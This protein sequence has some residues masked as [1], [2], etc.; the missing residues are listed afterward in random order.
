[1][2]RAGNVT[3]VQTCALPIFR[4]GDPADLRLEPH[5][6]VARPNG[7]SPDSNASATAPT[8]SG[9]SPPP[10]SAGAPP[11]GTLP[12][13]LACATRSTREIGR[14]SCRERGEESQHKM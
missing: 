1:S 14:T 6:L 2:I 12:E 4:V 10:S 3:G 13:P 7:R 9:S 11:T 8:P 5:Q